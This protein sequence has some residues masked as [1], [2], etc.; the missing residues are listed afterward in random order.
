M[1]RSITW[2]LMFFF[3]L[4]AVDLAAKGGSSEYTV[5]DYFLTAEEAAEFANGLQP[6]QKASAQFIAEFTE[7]VPSAKT[8]RVYYLEQAAAETSGKDFE[9]QNKEFDNLSEAVNFANEEK[10][11][12]RFVPVRDTLNKFDSY[13]TVAIFYRIP[14]E[15]PEGAKYRIV[16]K[17]FSEPS[18]AAEYAN[19]ELVGGDLRKMQFVAELYPAAQ[20]YNVWRIVY[21]EN[22]TAA[23]PA[24]KWRVMEN[25]D[26]GFPLQAQ[27]AADAV[28]RKKETV[29]LFAVAFNTYAMHSRVVVFCGQSDK[30][31]S[32]AK[33]ADYRKLF[34]SRLPDLSD[35]LCDFD[36]PEVRRVQNLQDNEKCR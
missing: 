5:S 27:T 22:Q 26:D 13:T 7:G 12:A 23:L 24:R 29:C 20:I 19:K 31:T 11:E 10:V 21:A 33:K 2:T 28:R 36:G 6:N 18:A 8:F 16:D 32:K 1:R 9:W 15:N 17:V 4:S 35:F 34:S 3:L 25:D 30:E 14:G